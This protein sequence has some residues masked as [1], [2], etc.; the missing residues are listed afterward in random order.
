MF[1]RE[2]DR[3]YPVITSARGAW[4][5]DAGG[6][7]YL[8][9]VSGGAMVTSLGQGVDEIID[10]AGEQARS[11]SFLYSQQFTSPP[12]EALAERLVGL[13]PE[14]FGRVHF[15]AG[16]AEANEAALRLARAYHVERGEPERWRI[17]SPAQ[18]YHGPTMSTLA[19]AGRPAMSR[20]FEPYLESHLHI[21]PATWRF[22]PSGARALE[23][24]D[25]ALEEAGPETVAAFFIEPVSAAALP[26]YAPPA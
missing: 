26:A 11:V 17:I 24:L 7:A 4:L 3:E 14:G 2:L 10:A 23:A 25:R 15:V 9:A 12:Q 5:H 13:A 8:D 22:D 1:V 18:A 16:G 21:P 19:L 6:M 20:P